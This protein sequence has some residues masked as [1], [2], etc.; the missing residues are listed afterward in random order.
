MEDK[1]AV[2][3]VELGFLRD[4]LIAAIRQKQTSVIEDLLDVY[5]ALVK[6][7]VQRLKQLGADYNMKASI[8]ESSSLEGGWVEERWLGDDIRL[9]IDEAFETQDGNIIYYGVRFPISLAYIAVN[10]KDYYTY[11]RCL[12]WLPYCVY[13]S[14]SIDKTTVRDAV[15]D[16]CT[17]HLKSMADYYLGP[18][19]LESRNKEEVERFKELIAGLLIVFKDLLK[20][21]YDKRDAKNFGKFLACLNRLF[22]YT[23]QD[24]TESRIEEAEMFN[25]LP[26]HSE[27]ASNNDFGDLVINKA[28]SRAISYINDVRSQVRFGMQA[29]VAEEYNR[30]KLNRQEVLDFYNRLGHYGDIAALTE[31]Y[32]QS[33]DRN[34][35]DL[36]GWHWWETESRL[37]EVVDMGWDVSFSRLYCLKALELL[38][39]VTL[40]TA[41]R[42][43]IP[44]RRSLLYRAGNEDSVI[45]KALAQIEANREKWEPIIGAEAIGASSVLR[46]LFKHAVERQRQRDL[47]QVIQANIDPSIKQQFKRNFITGWRETSDLRRIITNYGTYIA[48]EMAGDAPPDLSFLG[49]NQ[50]DPKD[51]YVK[52]S[53]VSKQ[54]LGLFY[55]QELGRS[56][57]EQILARILENIPKLNEEYSREAQ[58]KLVDIGLKTL[59][60]QGYKPNVILL[61]NTWT[62]QR[63]IVNSANWKKP[64]NSMQDKDAPI[65]TYDGVAVF[66][67]HKRGVRGIVAVG[68]LKRLGTWRQYRPRKLFPE[69]EDVDGMFS[70]L[71]REFDTN[72]AEKLIE[73]NPN[74]LIDPQT[75]QP[76]TRQETINQILQKV[77]LRIIEQFQ[78]FID[79]REA[80]IRI[81][82]GKDS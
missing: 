73:K 17:L 67:V 80:G 11:S 23:F 43:E 55:G 77:H 19:L 51:L 18:L 30:G 52:E 12:R 13:R 20:S 15:I 35:D 44:E 70:F 2:L 6:A 38:K 66:R 62:A 82:V 16:Q 50:T 46:E 54:D 22:E 48:P 33:V 24:F 79:D 64:S 25:N 7:F 26:N 9:I 57:N 37:G 34:S 21:T 69:E 58:L 8:E 5:E 45:L 29:W 76:R 10:E 36:F 74:W 81:A 14:Y 71:V 53:D 39:A 27:A 68:D 78:F 59:R 56:E 40:N 63:L 49:F 3:R 32:F 4:N 41:D 42:Y 47:N 65:G 1:S 72:S 60:D 61:L 31:I 28:I 75:K